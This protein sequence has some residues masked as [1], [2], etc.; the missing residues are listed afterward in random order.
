MSRP[1]QF[2]RSAT[3]DVS[4]NLTPLIDVVF[5]LLIFFMVTTTFERQ[6]RLDVELPT[7]EASPEVMPAERVDV[8]IDRDGAVA[9]EGRALVDSDPDTVERALAGSLRPGSEQVVVVTTDEQTPSRAILS[10]L[11]VIGDLGHSRVAFSAHAAAEDGE[12]PQGQ[13]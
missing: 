1:L 13:P 12:R 11:Q 9:V 6:T 7:V 3:D 10:V 2:R 4:I 5:L 8:V